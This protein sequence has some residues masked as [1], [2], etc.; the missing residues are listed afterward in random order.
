MIIGVWIGAPSSFLFRIWLMT[1]VVIREP[2]C[3]PRNLHS[4]KLL[5]WSVCLL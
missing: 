4:L 2:V 1:L 3:I 5:Q